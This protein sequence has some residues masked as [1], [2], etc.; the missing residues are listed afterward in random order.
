MRKE[1]MTGCLDIMTRC[2]RTDGGR[3]DPFKF[4]LLLIEE[5]VTLVRKVAVSQSDANS[6]KD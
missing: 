3:L 5:T 1:S 2:G 6:L 4:F